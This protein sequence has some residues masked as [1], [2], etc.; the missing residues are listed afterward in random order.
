MSVNISGRYLNIYGN[1]NVRVKRKQPKRFQAI[2]TYEILVVN[3]E[4][5]SRVRGIW[6][7][8]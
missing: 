3:N 4:H 8:T 5:T 7:R 1:R 2:I 6:K